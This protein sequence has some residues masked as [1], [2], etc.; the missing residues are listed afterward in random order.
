[1]SI[2]SEVGRLQK[3]KADLKTVIE[4]RGVA[5][6]N[7]TISNYTQLLDNCPYSMKGQFTPSEDTSTFSIQNLPFK[8]HTIII[9]NL[10]LYNSIISG[11]V[12]CYAQIN[13]YPG[14]F[15]CGAE[16][17]QS[18]TNLG[19]KKP[20]IIDVGIQNERIL[21]E[22]IHGNTIDVY[23]KSNRM[24]NIYYEQIKEM[25]SIVKK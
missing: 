6:G 14:V 18:L 3:A 17:G 2:A 19:I 11:A 25:A 10:E 22:D 20:M 1:M 13:T 5:V 23:V 4:K 21:K 9:S 7:T 16:D 12:I 15:T 8:P 24:K